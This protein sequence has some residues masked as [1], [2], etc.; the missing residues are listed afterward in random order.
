MLKPIFNDNTAE[1]DEITKNIYFYKKSYLKSTVSFNAALI[2]K[3]GYKCC[4]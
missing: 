1:F 3:I 2:F 4:T